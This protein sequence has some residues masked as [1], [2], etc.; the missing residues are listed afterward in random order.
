MASIFTLL[1]TR[2]ATTMPDDEHLAI[3][4]AQ[5]AL[6]SL[7]V[8]LAIEGIPKIGKLSAVLDKVESIIF[9]DVHLAQLKPADAVEYFML[10]NS[11]RK[12]YLD[13]TKDILRSTAWDKLDALVID[14]KVRTAQPTL[15]TTTGVDYAALAN[16]IAI[17]LAG[18]R[19]QPK[20][21]LDAIELNEKS[22][23]SKEGE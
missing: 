22:E 14:E 8:G 19:E 1:A 12:E 20:T 13:Y 6:Q 21:L 4:S 3:S 16:Q 7:L 17:Q 23:L 11:T 10:V 2:V 5:L 9:S 15:D 18:I